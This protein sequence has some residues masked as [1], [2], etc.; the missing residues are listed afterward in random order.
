MAVQIYR[1]SCSPC[2]QIARHA[3]LGNSISTL[4]DAL[5]Y[6]LQ[7]IYATKFY[8]C[9]YISIHF[10]ILLMAKMHKQIHIY[11]VTNSAIESKQSALKWCS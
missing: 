3:V 5:L 9:F 4:F 10:I 2:I 7:V 11:N 6:S 1:D 8:F